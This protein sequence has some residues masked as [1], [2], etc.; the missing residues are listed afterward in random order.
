VQPD[1]FRTASFR[2]ALFYAGLFSLS[3]FVLFVIIYLATTGF[4]AQQLAGRV[5]RELATL[6]TEYRISGRTNLMTQINARLDSAQGA[7]YLLEDPD[8]QV[9]AGNLAALPPQIG[10]VDFPAAGSGDHVRAKGA[11][12]QD[13][14]FLLV[15]LN[16]TRLDDLNERVVRSFLW[17]S[18]GTLILAIMGA[19]LMSAVSLRH[20]DGIVSAMEDIVDGNLSRRLP[21]LGSRDEFDRLAVQVNRMLDR[22]QSLMSG[23]QQVSND[24]AHDLKTPLTRLRHRLELVRS[25]PASVADYEAAVDHALAECDLTL[26]TFDALL[27]IAQIEAGTRR[28]GFK[29]VDLA[30]VIET[31]TTA[32]LPVAEEYGHR[33]SCE[34]GRDALVLGDPELLTQ[35]V[36]NLIENAF[37]HTPP[38]ST[39]NLLVSPSADCWVLTVKDDGPGIP[40]AHWDKVFQRFYRLD[41]SRSTAGSGLGL[42]LVA[43]VAQL[44]GAEIKLADN[45]PGLR[46]EIYFARHS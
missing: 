15:G 18:A 33:L 28:S 45:Q 26:A 39:I 19:I 17:G 23:L 44:H 8:G 29:I 4:T 46:V 37:K 25:R 7:F 1:L 9:L 5:E 6:K 27:R 13:G 43:A 41:P 12:L 11:R 10:W 40:A 31:L 35:M 30:A 3:V 42:S 14:D 16:A 20:I 22:I 21:L 24:I 2:I 38:G 34:T 32:Y 36:S